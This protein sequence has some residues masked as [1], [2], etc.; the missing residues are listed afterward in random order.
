VH[1]IDIALARHILTAICPAASHALIP[2]AL[3][4]LSHTNTLT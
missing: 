4:P 2:P 1:P 3:L